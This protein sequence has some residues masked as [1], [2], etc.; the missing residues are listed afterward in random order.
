MEIKTTMSY[1]FTSVRMAIIKKQKTGV[2]EDV[3]TLK[4]MYMILLV[5]K[6]IG[7]A[8]MENNVKVP[9]KKK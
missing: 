9:K 5:G 2:V 3:E 1:H 6:Q 4:S 7:T 8:I